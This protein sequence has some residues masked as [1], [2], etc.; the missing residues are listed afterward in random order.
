MIEASLK[1]V[2]VLASRHGLPAG[3]LV[4][5]HAGSNVVVHLAPAP[6]VVR[7]MTGTAELHG[8][9]AAWLEREVSVCT[10]LERLGA[11]IVAPSIELPPGPH[12]VD[13]L[14]M[15]CWEHVA[16]DHAAPAPP[17]AELGRALGEL[18]SAMSQVP[19]ELEP[20]TAVREELSGLLDRLDR[21]DDPRAN[22]FRA[23]LA[24]VSIVAF[25][26][27]GSVGQPV[28][29]DASLSNLL[30]TTSGRRLWADF[31]DVRQGPVEADVAGLIDAARNRGLGH[32][33]ETALL[34]AYG[35]IDAHVYE[36]QL[37]LHALYGAVWRAY[38]PS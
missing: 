22:G 11:A 33:Y 15:T 17:P 24:R 1:A 6:V 32:G 20:L 13:G 14:W 16:V 27:A 37:Q 36:A 30:T 7:V 21:R 18:H 2:H 12:H 9:P 28:H 26:T 25:G 10:H 8:D 31:E 35:P 29:G 4:V 3:G 38:H 34:S 5:L 23:Q 19:V